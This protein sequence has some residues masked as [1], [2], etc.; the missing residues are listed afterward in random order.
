MKLFKKKK[1]WPFPQ[2]VTVH[3]VINGV[4]REVTIR[5]DELQQIHMHHIPIDSC[6]R[7]TNISFT[8]DMIILQKDPPSDPKAPHNIDK[9][10]APNYGTYNYVDAYDYKG[11]HLW[12]ISEI[13]GDIGSGVHSG[14][15]CSTDFLIC[16]SKQAYI[17][18]HELFVCWNAYGMRYMI[19]L[20][21]KKVIH[22]VIT[23]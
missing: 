9:N 7:I 11:N 22:K 20:D 1:P 3:A 21:D 23:K 12:N 4:H 6:G 17:E 19:D 14:H 13:L 5:T 8:K 16:D 2:R 15:V 10:Y 18:G